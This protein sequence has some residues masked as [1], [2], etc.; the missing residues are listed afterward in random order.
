VGTA[1][2]LPPPSAL[3]SATAA[4]SSSADRAAQTVEHPRRARPVATVRPIPDE[5]PGHDR[6][7]PGKGCCGFIHGRALRRH[8][9]LSPCS[10]TM[11]YCYSLKPSLMQ[12]ELD[13]LP[14]LKLY[15]L[16]VDATT[17]SSSKTLDLFG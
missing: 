15:R 13:K 8:D 6:N 3:T 5:R 11:A 1:I 17:Q 7:L 2:A 12:I 10:G 16:R 4:P 9:V 14:R